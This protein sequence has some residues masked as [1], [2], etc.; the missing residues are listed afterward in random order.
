VNKVQLHEDKH[1]LF[2]PFRVPKYRIQFQNAKKLENIPGYAWYTPAALYL[3]GRFTEKNLSDL[4]EKYNL[5]VYWYQFDKPI[6]SGFAHGED[7][8]WNHL[9]WAVRIDE[10]QKLVDGILETVQFDLDKN[11]LYQY[12]LQKLKIYDPLNTDLERVVLTSTPVI[13]I[14]V[15]AVL[16]NIRQ[17]A[18]DT[19][20]STQALPGMVSY[21]PDSLHVKAAKRLFSLSHKDTDA[22]FLAYKRVMTEMQDEA[23]Y[24]DVAKRGKSISSK[25]TNV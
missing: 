1:Y 2:K 17:C 14:S 19:K 23:Y 13:E 3:W 16:S 18:F 11:V 25:R 15:F 24:L 20:K 9:L 22:A 12:A 5:S 21:P 10:Y 4:V 7:K 6:F 8:A